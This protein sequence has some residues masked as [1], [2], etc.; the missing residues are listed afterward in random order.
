MAYLLL[1]GLQYLHQ[2]MPRSPFSVL[3]RLFHTGPEHCKKLSLRSLSDEEQQH[4]SRPTNRLTSWLTDLS[5]HKCVPLLF[6]FFT[7]AGLSSAKFL[8]GLAKNVVAQKHKMSGQK[9]K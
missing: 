4:Q 2:P 6:L 9:R 1:L 7:Q 3:P 8:K 5:C